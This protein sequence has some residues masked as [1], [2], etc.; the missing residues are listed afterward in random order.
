M[1][2]AFFHMHQKDPWPRL[3]LQLIWPGSGDDHP[4]CDIGLSIDA[5]QWPMYARSRCPLFGIGCSWP[6]WSCALGIWLMEEFPWWRC[7][8]GEFVALSS[9]WFFSCNHD[10]HGHVDLWCQSVSSQCLYPSGRCWL[11][12][13]WWQLHPDD[14]FPGFSGM[15]GRDG[16]LDRIQTGCLLV[17]DHESFVG[18]LVLGWCS[19]WLHP[20][21]HDHVHWNPKELNKTDY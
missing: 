5:V 13:R 16:R 1:D 17:Q 18:S 15:L 14:L 11:Q 4:G 2:D 3:L 21:S 8:K 19:P 12:G 10:S 6:C 20:H 7:W 9:Q